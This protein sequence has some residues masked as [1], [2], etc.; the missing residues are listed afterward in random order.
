MTGTDVRW[1]G[2]DVAVS[3]QA[4]DPD[5]FRVVFERAGPQGKAKLATVYV[6]GGEE[7]TVTR[8]VRP[9]RSGASG[10]GRSEYERKAIAVVRS[11]GDALPWD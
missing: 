10:P 2:V 8:F 6:Q 9:T 11:L 4:D 3:R 1:A 7:P 5:E